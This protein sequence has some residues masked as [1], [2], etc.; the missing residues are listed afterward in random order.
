M[1]SKDVRGVKISSSY[2][3]TTTITRI[4]YRSEII[5]TAQ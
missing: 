5:G 2:E 1:F 4:T 3:D